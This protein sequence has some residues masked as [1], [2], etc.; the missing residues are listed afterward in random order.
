MPWNEIK[1]KCKARK[2]YI[3]KIRF[4]SQKTATFLPSCVPRQKNVIVGQNGFFITN[5]T[6]FFYSRKQDVV[7]SS[8]KKNTNAKFNF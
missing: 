2:K 7:N 6:F 4:A 5:L 8:N 3:Y 1:G